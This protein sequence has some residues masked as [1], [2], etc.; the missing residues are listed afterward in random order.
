MNQDKVAIVTGGGS[1]LGQAV[2]L[3]LAESDA[4]IT[5][6]DISEKAGQET[7]SLSFRKKSRGD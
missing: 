4:S 3:K 1:G 2:A 7:V 5:I 6:V